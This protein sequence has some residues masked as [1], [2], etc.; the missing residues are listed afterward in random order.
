MMDWVCKKWS[1]DRD[2]VI[3]TGMRDEP[4]TAGARHLGKRYPKMFTKV[5]ARGGQIRSYADCV[6]GGDRNTRSY[7]SDLQ[8][9]WGKLEWGI[10]ADTGK[11]I[12]D[13]IEQVRER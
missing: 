9:L 5:K 6:R 4:P 1:I 13:E 11:P 7:G 8:E 10:P 2:L 12:W 3:V